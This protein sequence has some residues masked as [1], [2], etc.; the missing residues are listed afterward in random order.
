M[1]LQQKSLT[2]I[3]LIFLSILGV[4]FLSASTSHAAP[5]S[6]ILNDEF[7]LAAAVSCEVSMPNPETNERLVLNV[8]EVPNGDIIGTVDDGE[9]VEL[10]SAGGIEGL[11]WVKIIKPVVGFVWTEHLT[12]CQ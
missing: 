2:I 4:K 6:Q 1:N 5:Q 12:N 11:Y 7:L 8:R 9:T 3:P 10:E